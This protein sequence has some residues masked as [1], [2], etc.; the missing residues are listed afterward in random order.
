MPRKCL[1]CG[2]DFVWRI[3]VAGWTNALFEG[4]RFREESQGLSSKKLFGARE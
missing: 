3:F 2:K 1:Q 4:G